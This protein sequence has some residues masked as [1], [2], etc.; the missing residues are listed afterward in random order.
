MS[1]VAEHWI[2]TLS[3]VPH[4]EGGWFRETFRSPERLP[5][6]ALPPRFTGERSLVTSILFLLAAGE[7]SHLH[8]LRADE[9]WWHHAGGALHLHLL[10]SDGARRLVVSESAPQAVVPHGTWLAAEPEPG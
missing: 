9:Q 4:R 1:A 5:A 6:A 3:L 7:R 10:G 8:R 2:R